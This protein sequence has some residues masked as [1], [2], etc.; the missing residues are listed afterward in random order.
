MGCRKIYMGLLSLLSPFS[1]FLQLV[2][3]AKDSV[4]AMGQ[5]FL[6]QVSPLLISHDYHMTIT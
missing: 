5:C 4:E 6:D 1:T 3:D 2:E